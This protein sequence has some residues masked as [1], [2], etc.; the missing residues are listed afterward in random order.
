MQFVPKE[1]ADALYSWPCAMVGGF[2]VTSGDRFFTNRPSKQKACF[3]LCFGVLKHL[4]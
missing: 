4:F 1:C 3:C 2:L